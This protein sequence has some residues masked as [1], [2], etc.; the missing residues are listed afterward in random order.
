MNWIEMLGVV[1]ACCTTG[2]F[3][4]QAVKTIREKDTSG[5]SAAMY[6]IFTSGTVL[7]LA[8][9]LLTGNLPIILANA[10]TSLL[11]ATILFYKFRY[12]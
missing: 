11:A 4:P 2:S 10:I 5:I 9:G 7:W 1:A 3:L 6:T 12:R 8:Y